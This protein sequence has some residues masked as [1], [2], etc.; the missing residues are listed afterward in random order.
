[1]INP[2][3]VSSSLIHWWGRNS[4]DDICVFLNNALRDPQA[5]AALVRELIAGGHCL[6]PMIPYGVKKEGQTE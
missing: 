4:R 1:M 2:E 5:R 3:D 6:P